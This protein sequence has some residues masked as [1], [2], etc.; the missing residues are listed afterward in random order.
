MDLVTSLAALVALLVGLAVGK[1]WER[2]KLQDGRLIDR[3]RARESPHYM[4]GLN[5]LVTGQIDPA[6]EEL[7]KAAD[8]TGDALEIR[9][10]L[11]NLYRE[12]G[13]VGRA[14]QEH[15]GLLQRPN[16]RKL[17]HANVLLCLGLDYRRGGF[18]D[19]AI[20]AFSEVLRLDPGNE[21]ALVNLQKLH[22]EQ[23]QW[24]D[25]HAAR[26]KLAAGAAADDKPRHQRILAF[27]EDAIGLEA[28]NQGDSAAAAQRFESAIELDPV[29]TPAYLHL[30]DVRFRTGDTAGAIA[31]WERLVNSSPDRGYL[32]FPRLE[33]AYGK[34]GEAS[35]FPELCRRLIAQTPQD[36]RAR[37]ALAAHLRWNGQATEG[38]EILFEALA[39]NPHALAVHQAIW[40]LLSAVDL[41]RALVDRYFELTRQS[42]FYVDPHI[43]VR[44]RYRSTELLWQCPQ[45]HEWDTFIEERIAPARDTDA[46]T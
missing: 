26:Q 40:E 10:M 34:L 16:L 15:Q 14:I 37:L 1:A 27:L 9:L 12:K 25:A 39:I 41:P 6:I 21:Y 4:L 35:R 3:R 45:C 19:R 28:V 11:G 36:W 33:T 20:E 23:H 18:V 5:F 30:G 29:N 8:L 17:E 43:C 22:E 46:M 38:L 7:T 13:Q 44:C 31:A 32:A 24:R 2:Y 42:V